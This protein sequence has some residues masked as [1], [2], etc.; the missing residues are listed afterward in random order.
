MQS[1][2]KGDEANFN[3]GRFYDLKSMIQKETSFLG[4]E[5]HFFKNGADVE[6]FFLSGII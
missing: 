5:E 6:Q 2:P 1:Y 3:N 4:S